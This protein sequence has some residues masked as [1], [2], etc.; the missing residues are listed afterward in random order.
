ML[1]KKEI[2]LGQTRY[3][4]LQFLRGAEK[5]LFTMTEIANKLELS[6]KT[7]KAR[8]S[9]MA[10]MGIV[11]KEYCAKTHVTRLTVREEWLQ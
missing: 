11:D 1:T 8:L 4:I 7:V 9:E 3:F 2:A 10:Q 6:D 5:T